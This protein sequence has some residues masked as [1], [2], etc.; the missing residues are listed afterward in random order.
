MKAQKIIGK[1]IEKMQK[2][3]KLEMGRYLQKRGIFLVKVL[4]EKVA[5]RLNVS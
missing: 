2:D 5:H 4:I 1:S 3:D